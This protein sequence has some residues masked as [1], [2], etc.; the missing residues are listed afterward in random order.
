M[1]FAL[2]VRRTT[3]P[4]DF[5]PS[6]SLL[7]RLQRTNTLFPHT[8]AKAIKLAFFFAAAL[9]LCA[10]VEAAPQEARAK[11]GGRVTDPQGAV[12]PSVIVTVISDDTGIKYQTRT[13]TQG[14]WI[15]EFLLPGSYRFRV[16]APGFRTAERLG[17]TLQTADDKEMDV[18]LEVGPASESI[19]VPSGTQ[20]IDT[21]SAT[22]GTVI[23]SEELEELPTSS[24]VVTLFSTLSPGVAAQYQNNN[25][26]HLWSFNAASQF[27]AN[28]G[29][30]NIYYNN[31]LLDGMPNT[32]SGGDIAF[33][34]PMDSVRE[35]RILTNAYDASIERQ[36]GSTV[37]LQTK[38]GAKNYHG[39]LYEYNQNNLL[40]ANY[41]QNN[42]AGAPNPR[43]ISTSSEAH[44][45][46]PCGFPRCI[47]ERRK[48]FSL[49]RTR[50]RTT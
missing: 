12:V 42:L 46:G 1:S 35:F 27:D 10:P 14:N 8:A 29:R 30:N 7:M 33:I 9:Y 19:V 4:K 50:I 3:G 41:F 26:A 48:R 22:S 43:C 28:G 16:T 31:Y 11:L 37:N 38:T 20:L 36:A 40:N 45:A 25:V 15:V 34:P 32:K 23:T 17:I 6:W 39:N 21:T 47:A 18:Q 13:N 49:S 5:T 24:H 2:V 44:L